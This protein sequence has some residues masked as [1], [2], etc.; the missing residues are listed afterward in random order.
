[1]LADDVDPSRLERARELAIDFVKQAPATTQIGLV[2][3]SDLASVLVPPTT[4]REVLLDALAQVQPAQNTSL[5]AAIV[6]GVRMMPG[7]RGVA[8]PEALEPPAGFAGVPTP[9]NPAEIETNPAP[10]SLLI[11]SDGV[12]NVSDNPELALNVA[13]DI[14]A[15][16]A[17]DNEVK[18]YTIA[19]GRTGG[20][21]AE[22]DG[23]N[24]FIPFE[25][26]NLERLAERSDGQHI[27]PADSEALSDIYRD[28]STVI[29]W[30]AREIEVSVLF[31]GLAAV[32]MLLA[33]GL[34]LRLRRSVP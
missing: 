1:M 21:V 4:D 15:G 3:F 22:V 24:Y 10:G 12:S 17:A 28:L 29:R 13:L 6:T 34:S 32:L 27:F 16:F 5:T 2:S 19:L 20:T 31:T 23:Q 18:L 33:A 9:E 7:R 14:A 25:P 11:F 8:P 30:E 26:E